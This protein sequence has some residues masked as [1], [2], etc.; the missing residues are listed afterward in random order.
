M[1]QSARSHKRLMQVRV[2][3]VSVP[4]EYRRAPTSCAI[5]HQRYVYIAVLPSA[6]FK[7][8]TERVSMNSESVFLSCNGQM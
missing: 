2:P 3:T 7:F 6:V 4:A 5:V 8:C 1:G